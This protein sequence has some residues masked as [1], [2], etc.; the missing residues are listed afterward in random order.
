MHDIRGHV[1]GIYMH[2]GYFFVFVGEVL[3]S[4]GGHCG[5]VVGAGEKAVVVFELEI[6]F[7]DLAF[8][9]ACEDGND[10]RIGC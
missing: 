4:E 9:P 3:E 7:V 5:A 10:V 1:P 6:V 8:L 2:E